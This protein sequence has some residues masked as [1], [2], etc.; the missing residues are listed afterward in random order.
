MGEHHAGA[1]SPF[2]P[3]FPF[4]RFAAV[5]LMPF[6][7]IAFLIASNESLRQDGRVRRGGTGCHVVSILLLRMQQ[8]L[9]CLQNLE[10]SSTHTSEGVQVWG[11]AE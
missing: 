11:L 3:F 10:S 5:L 2:T 8:A 4:G 7:M 1:C 9:L 6:V